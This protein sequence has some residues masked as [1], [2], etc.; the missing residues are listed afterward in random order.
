MSENGNL[1]KRARVME[2]GWGANSI[3]LPISKQVLEWKS[4]DYNRF[5]EASGVWF[6]KLGSFMLAGDVAVTGEGNNGWWSVVAM[7]AASVMVG[8]VW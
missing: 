7:G 2:R 1:I 5:C 6:Q 3:G 4:T 8:G